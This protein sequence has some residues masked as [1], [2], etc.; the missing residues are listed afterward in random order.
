VHWDWIHLGAIVLV[1]LTFMLTMVIAWLV[2][3]DGYV[4]GWRAART[5]P[6]LCP[7]CKYNLSGL[8][9]C[10][11][12]ECGTEYRLDHLWRTPVVAEKSTTDNA[13]EKVQQSRAHVEAPLS[14]RKVSQGS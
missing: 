12:P 14:I 1:V 11:C 8:T 3:R 4:R 10:R 5:N 2:W 6:P 7:N 9:H 13:P